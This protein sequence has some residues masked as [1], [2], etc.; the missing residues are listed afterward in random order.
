VTASAGSDGSLRAVT[1]EFI[2]SRRYSDV[3]NLDLRLAKNI[4][5]GGS[6]LTLS[7]EAFNIFNSGVVLSRARFAN[8][9]AFTQTI[10]GSEPGLGRIEEILVP[11][12]LRIG[13]RFQ[14]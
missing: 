14:F 6:T 7:A 13:A 10:A 4:K 11:R 12:I 3:W 2:D 8:S 5:F 9:S 1:D